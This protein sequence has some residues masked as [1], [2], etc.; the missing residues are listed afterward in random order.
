MHF[1]QSSRIHQPDIQELAKIA[2]MSVKEY[3]LV[4]RPLKY[5]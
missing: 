1:E 2:G 3:F 5:C 4:V